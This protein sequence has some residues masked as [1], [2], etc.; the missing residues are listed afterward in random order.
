MRRIHTARSIVTDELLRKSDYITGR[1]NTDDFDEYDNWGPGEYAWIDVDDHIAQ[2][3][4]AGLDACE[5]AGVSPLSRAGIELRWKAIH[6]DTPISE[7]LLAWI[8]RREARL[9]VEAEARR[10]HDQEVSRYQRVL[11]GYVNIGPHPR[12]S[13]AVPDEVIY[14]GPNRYGA[15]SELVRVDDHTIVERLSMSANLWTR[16]PEVIADAEARRGITGYIYSLPLAETLAELERTL[17]PGR[18]S[19]LGGTYRLDEFQRTGWQRTSSDPRSS[20]DLEK[21]TRLRAYLAERAEW[22]ATNGALVQRAMDLAVDGSITAT[23]WSPNDVVGI[24]EIADKL[25]VK[26]AT[27]D[28]WRQRN[29]G[30]PEPT[31]T[32]GGRPAWLWVPVAA[33]AYHTGRLPE[34]AL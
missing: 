10:R 1:V 29:V 7:R 5:H 12:C 15:R 19:W 23:H 26:R 24:P 14:S 13:D 18:P 9:A 21:L 28:V 34:S 33:W 4:D 17:P 8:D 6:G 32:V 31:H 25:G 11:S 30:F 16:D 27:V 2:A 3:W 22:D 20:T